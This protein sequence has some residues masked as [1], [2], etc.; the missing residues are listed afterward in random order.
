MPAYKGK[1]RRGK[2][3]IAVAGY[4]VPGATDMRIFRMRRQCQKFIDMGFL[5]Q[6][7]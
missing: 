4:H 6:L 1:N 2:L 7:G 5:H 3:V